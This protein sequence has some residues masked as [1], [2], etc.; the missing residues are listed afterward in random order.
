MKKLI[1]MLIS[2]IYAF[3]AVTKVY[4]TSDSFEA[5]ENKHQTIFTGSVNIKKLQ[6]NI[7]ANLAVVDF[8]K[9]N[10][11]IKY[12]AEDSVTFTIVL[13]NSILDGSCDELVYVPNSKNYILTGHVKINETPTN[14]KIQATKVIIDTNIN[15]I[16]IFGEKN[17]PVKF[18]FEV[19]DK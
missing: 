2:A 13:K 16:N 10:K 17:R 6:D 11:P 14:R 15:K 3:S 18:I 5:D 1:M 9:E 12:K 8:D 4:I 7:R 19:E